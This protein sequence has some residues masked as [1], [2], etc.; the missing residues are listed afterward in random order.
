MRYVILRDDD[1]NALTPPEYLEKLYRPF[2]ERGLPVNLAAIPN[3]ATTTTLPDNRPEGYL[4]A[5]TGQK[6]G[7]MPIGSN[8]ELVDYLLENPGFHVIQHGFEHDRFEF[9]RQDPHEI[10]RRLEW[11]TQ[12][13]LQAGFP[14]PQTFVA[15]YDRFSRVSLSAAARR[16]RVVSSGWYE[17]HRLPVAWWPRYLIKKCLGTPHWRA[18]GAVLLTHPGCLLSAHRP[19]ASRLAEVKRAVEKQRLTVLVTHW[20]EYF[21]NSKP[22]EEFIHQLHLTAEYLADQPDLRVISFGDLID[23]E[24]AL[25]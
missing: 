10:E 5:M 1:T 23:N 4:V 19:R 16:F 9:D 13:L 21:P 14:R 8:R 24:L 17:L 18:A 20:W 2:L 12:L 11:G 15:P 22:D 3:V 6:P 7:T 25:N